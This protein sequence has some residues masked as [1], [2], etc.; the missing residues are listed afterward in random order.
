MAVVVEPFLNVGGGIVLPTGFL[1]RLRELCDATGTLLVLDE[2]FTG[3]GRTGR[4][5]ACL[6][7]DVAP[8]IVVSSKGLA[9]GYVPIAA[10]TVARHVHDSFTAEPVIGGLLYGHTTAGHALGCAAGLAT[11]DVIEREGLLDRASVLGT[12]LRERLGP[13]VA[14]AP[15]VTDV[16]GLGLVAVVDTVSQRAA[17]DIRARARARGLLIRQQ[18][19]AVLAVPP[20]IVDERGIGEIAERLAAAVR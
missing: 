3:F 8:D 15:E 2:V 5:F 13:L 1:P 12:L 4:M 17:T 19:Q 9:S 14:A 6:H 18:G 16:R 7:E 20:L 10:V 11:L